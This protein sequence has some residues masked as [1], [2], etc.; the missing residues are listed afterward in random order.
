M[1]PTHTD[2][3]NVAEGLNRASYYSL[4]RYQPSVSR[5]T[6]FDHDSITLAALLA[7]LTEESPYENANGVAK[8]LNESCKL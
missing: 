6:P 1:S 4:P 5:S 2:V 8:V 3:N 7:G